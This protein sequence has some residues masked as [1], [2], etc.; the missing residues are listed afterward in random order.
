M[1]AAP[2]PPR[3]DRPRAASAACGTRAPNDVVVRGEHA[4][5]RR[6]RVAPGARRDAA[7]VLK[8][9]TSTEPPLGV[10]DYAHVT[11][12]EGLGRSTVAPQRRSNASAAPT[13]PAGR[14]RLRRARHGSRG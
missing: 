5:S 11:A 12:Y 8:R 2:A 10:S 14:S 9:P 1:L 6:V 13:R 7:T 4:V 3:R